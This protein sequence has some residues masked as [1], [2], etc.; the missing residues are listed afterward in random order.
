MDDGPNPEPIDYA[1][2]AAIDFVNELF[3]PE[4][5]PTG[6]NKVALVTFASSASLDRQ[7]TTNKNAVIN[8]INSIVTGGS[9]NIQ[10]ALVKAR[11]ELDTRGTFNCETSRSIILLTDG[12]ANRDNSGNNCSSTSSNTICQQNAIAA[13][14]AAWVINKGGNPY[15]QSVFT[16]G[17]TGAI[18]GTEEDI[19]LN[20]LDQI[21]NAGA[22]HTED[23][24]DLSDIYLEIFGNLNYAAIQLPG[25]KFLTTTIIPGFTIVSGSISTNKGTVTLSG[26]G[27]QIYW[28]VPKIATESI[29]LKYSLVASNSNVCGT[30]NPDSSVV[31][32]E[33]GD[34]NPVTL[35][36]TN[37]D[38]CVPCPSVTASISQV[39]CENSVDYNAN[40]SSGA[41][42]A[43]AGTVQWEFFL[44]NVPVGTSSQVSGTYVY[45]GGG[46]FEG[47]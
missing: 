11:A 46:T 42:S 35:N 19:A 2:D 31:K 33:D 30:Q 10:D 3:K 34:C 41:C 6:L 29:F 26:P 7:L 28:D 13:G 24:A 17:L 36:L 37:P 39:S 4:N 38:V 40:Y 43:P 25:Q 21:Q 8:S 47:D 14:Q 1:Q 9:T 32:Y 12:V 20:T 15:N 23:N 5:N 18:S 27:D 16:I 44:N 45:T 22:Y